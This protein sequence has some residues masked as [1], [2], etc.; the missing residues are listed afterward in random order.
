MPNIALLAGL[1]GDVAQPDAFEF[2]EVVGEGSF[3]KVYRGVVK[4]TGEEVAIKQIALEGDDEALKE[5][6]K[7]ISILKKCSSPFV[8][9]YL[10]YFL[11]EL[12]LHIVLELCSAGSVADLMA[13]TS[14]SLDEAQVY[15]FG[16][17]W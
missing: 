9:R 14:R 5:T 8:C 1:E 11:I 6:L 15:V 13:A 2:K 4:S 7:E 12:D 10:A 3:G 16:S 17:P